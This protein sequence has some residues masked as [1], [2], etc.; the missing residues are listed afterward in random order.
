M[1]VL[2]N[3]K[4]VRNNI[5]INSIFVFAT[6]DVKTVEVCIMCSDQYPYQIV[7]DILG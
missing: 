3:V 5:K 2:H 7:R 6:V 1:H 4:F